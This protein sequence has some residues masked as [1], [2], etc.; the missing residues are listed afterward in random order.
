MKALTWHGKRDVRGFYARLGFRP[1]G[2]FSGDQE[3]AELELVRAGRG[4][5][6]GRRRVARVF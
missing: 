1:T 4:G 2:G 5:R 3:I 6:P